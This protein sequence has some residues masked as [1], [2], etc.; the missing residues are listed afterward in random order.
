MAENDDSD[1]VAESLDRA[2]EHL[3]KG[4]RS[5]RNVID[6]A[7]QMRDAEIGDPVTNDQR[8]INGETEL[9]AMQQ[10][11]DAVHEGDRQAL[12]DAAS[13]MPPRG[14]EKSPGG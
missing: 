11:L 10:E 9:A 6:V 13:T 4:M 1:P 7:D 5:V 14:H 12:M 8:I 3:E 2:S